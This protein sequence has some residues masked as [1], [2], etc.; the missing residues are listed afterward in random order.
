[1]KNTVTA[2]RRATTYMDIRDAVR[3]QEYG[4]VA[5]TLERAVTTFQVAPTPDTLRDVQSVYM[6]AVRLLGGGT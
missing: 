3:R 5:V 2:L 6:R 1:M 4:D